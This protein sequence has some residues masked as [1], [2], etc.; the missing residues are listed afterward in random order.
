MPWFSLSIS[1]SPAQYEDCKNLEADCHCTFLYTFLPCAFS[2]EFRNYLY[3]ILVNFDISLRLGS[4]S[5]V[6]SR[7][8]LCPVYRLFLL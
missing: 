6:Y 4:T 7:M 1:E 8:S 3:Q 2:Y 5:M